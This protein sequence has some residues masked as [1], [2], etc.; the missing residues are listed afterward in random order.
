MTTTTDKNPAASLSFTLAFRNGLYKSE[1]IEL[2]LHLSQS[3]FNPAMQQ[4][5]G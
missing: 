5:T 2:I 3:G 1:T 4:L